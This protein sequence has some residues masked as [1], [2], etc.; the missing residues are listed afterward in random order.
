MDVPAAKDK[1]GGGVH[2]T[3]VINLRVCIEDVGQRR[4]G[5]DLWGAKENGCGGEGRE[6]GEVEEKE[7]NGQAK[8]EDPKSVVMP[9]EV[10]VGPRDS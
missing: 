1:D 8:G 9:V 10:F 2:G 6:E 7:E 4:I 3:Y 5:S